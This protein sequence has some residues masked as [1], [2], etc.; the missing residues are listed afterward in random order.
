MNMYSLITGASAGIGRAL[1]YECA[2]RKM[3]LI[4]VALPDTGLEELAIQLRK[5][6]GIIAEYFE[7]D[8]RDSDAPQKL[9][10]WCESKGF[11]VNM[12]INNA[13]I[14]HSGRLE[15]HTLENIADMIDLNI[16]SLVLLTRLFIP[17]LKK[18]KHSYILNMASLGGYKPVPYKS[19]YS[20]TK[21]YVYN[22]TRAIH[23]ELK[24]TSVKVSVCAPGAVTTNPKVIER[25]R[26]GGFFARISR[27]SPQQ[28]ASYSIPRL[29]KGKVVIV[30]GLLN[31]TLLV[32]NSFVPMRLQLKLLDVLFRNEGIPRNKNR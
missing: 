10:N 29:L 23:I 13:G 31:R 16:R 22:F 27:L 7:V 25:I 5:K 9:F 8:L 2:R 19:V 26:A 30:P 12:L 28:V 3:N 17:E 4:L 32:L 1:A 20:A 18:H 6:Y 21:T 14:G 11:R 24:N 15:K